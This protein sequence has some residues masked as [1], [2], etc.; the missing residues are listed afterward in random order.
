MTTSNAIRTLLAFAREKIVA[1]R[2]KRIE[3]LDV[4]V[5]EHISEFG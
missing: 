2:G 1:L 4:G 3:L 5:I